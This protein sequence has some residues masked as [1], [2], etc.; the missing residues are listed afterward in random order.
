MQPEIFGHRWRNN[1]GTKLRHTLN[2][3]VLRDFWTQSYYSSKVERKL[4]VRSPCVRVIE[5][6]NALIEKLGKG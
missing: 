4:K 6:D 3:S 1:R 5:I 2:Q